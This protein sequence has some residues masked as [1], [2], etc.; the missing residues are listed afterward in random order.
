MLKT[1]VGRDRIFMNITKDLHRVR[2]PDDQNELQGR[3]LYRLFVA[4]E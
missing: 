1:G 2:G 4:L 3:L